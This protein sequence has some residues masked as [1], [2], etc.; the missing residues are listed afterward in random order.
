MT[1]KACRAPAVTL[2]QDVE[3][4]VNHEVRY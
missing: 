2:K 1:D 3:Q 4:S